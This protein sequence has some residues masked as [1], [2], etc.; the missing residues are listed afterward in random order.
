[1][2]ELRN[3]FIPTPTHSS[4][5]APAGENAEGMEVE[6]ETEATC[7]ETF[8]RASGAISGKVEEVTEVLVTELR[9]AKGKLK[10]EVTERKRLHNLVQEVC[11]CVCLC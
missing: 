11:V 6:E 7:E 1:M 4:A 10:K 5:A 9:E 3:A 2:Q 8:E